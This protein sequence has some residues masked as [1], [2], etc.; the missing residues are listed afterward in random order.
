MRD[1]KSLDLNLLKAFDALFDER[2][3]TRAADRLGLTQPAVSGMLG[4]LRDSF[5]DPLFVRTQRGIVPTIRAEEL[6]TPIRQ[7]LSEV[8][9]LLQPA[10][11]DP[12]TA[13]FT[14]SLA[15]TDYALHAVV[16]PF[17]Q[18][19]GGSRPASGLQFFPLKTRIRKRALSEVSLISHSLHLRRHRKTCTRAISLTKPMSVPP[20]PAI[21]M[22]QAGQSPWIGS[23]AS[24]TSWF[25][26]LVS[27]FS[28]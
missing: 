28:V 20:K 15:A 26:F 14:V 17:C 19:F 6:A 18:D 8:G 5:D 25:R 3:V 23:A 10:V 22:R 4:R 12:S 24:I 16:L 7:I 13:E 11:F 21:Q 27:D 9:G 1:I 2:N